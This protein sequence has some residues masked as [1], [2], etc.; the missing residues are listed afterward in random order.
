MKTFTIG[1]GEKKANEAIFAKDVAEHLGT[2]HHELYVGQED[3]L[4][5]VDLITAIGD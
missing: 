1:F 5:H 3:L 4:K 2:E